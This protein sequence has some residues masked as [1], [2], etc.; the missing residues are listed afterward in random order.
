MGVDLQTVVHSLSTVGVAL[1]ATGLADKP[2]FIIFTL[3]AAIKLAHA[4]TFPKDRHAV[5]GHIIAI[6][7]GAPLLSTCTY[8]L[9]ASF[10]KLIAFITNHA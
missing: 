3:C 10:R 9:G 5:I 4:H 7:I 1:G 2:L 6:I 8:I